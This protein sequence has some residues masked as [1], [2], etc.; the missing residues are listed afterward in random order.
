MVWGQYV[1][2]A[3]NMPD[4][5]NSNHSDDEDDKMCI[6]RNRPLTYDDWVTWYSTDLMNLWMGIKAYKEDS[7]NVSYILDSVNYS[8]FCEF[9]YAF[10]SKMRSLF[11]S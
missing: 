8:D 1:Q 5:D 7:G 2:D 4:A 10:S 9:C 11:P 6:P 3:T